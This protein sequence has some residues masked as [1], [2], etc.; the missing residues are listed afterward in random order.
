MCSVMQRQRQLFPRKVRMVF[1]FPFL[2]FRWRD[3][4]RP[5]GDD[6]LQATG[7]P[8]LL[9]HWDLQCLRH[10]WFLHPLCLPPQHGHSHWSLSSGCFLPRVGNVGLHRCCFHYNDLQVIGISNTLGR[11]LAGW[12]SDFSWVS[13][14]IFC[15]NH[16]ATSIQ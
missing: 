1:Q 12:V 15:F 8:P 11:V 10:D 6:E 13:F 9:P 14:I 4:R 3:A 7:R 2:L 5:Q 16:N